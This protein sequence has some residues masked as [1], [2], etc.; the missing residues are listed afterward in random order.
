MAEGALHAAIATFLPMATLGSGG[1]LAGGQGVGL[2][3]Y[4]L[5]VF[6]AVVVVANCRLA[7]ENKQWT[8]LFAV[9]LAL[10]LVAFIMSW[11]IFAE[12]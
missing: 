1:V 11:F 9:V 3:G 7:M 2:W 8:L 6:F 10:S 4:G 12:V 5:T